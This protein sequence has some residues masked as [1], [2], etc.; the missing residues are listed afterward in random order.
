MYFIIHS[1]IGVHTVVFIVV[2]EIGYAL[3]ISHALNFTDF[4]PLRFFFYG[5]PGDCIQRNPLH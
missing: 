3:L 1:N 2:Q 5:V 4:L